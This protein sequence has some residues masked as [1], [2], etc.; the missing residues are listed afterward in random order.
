MSEIFQKLKVPVIII[1]ILFGGFIVYN[2]FIKAPASNDLIKKESVSSNNGPEQDFLPLL[3]RI[4]NVT[5]DE[6]LFLDPVFR[7]LVDFGQPIIP[8]SIGK[9]NP[10]MGVLVGSVNSSVESLGFV[11]GATD[12]EVNSVVKKPVVKPVIKK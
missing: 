4:Q 12:T 1:S 11:D 3:L 2:N 5:L 6:K 9:S 10:F 8:E 7:A